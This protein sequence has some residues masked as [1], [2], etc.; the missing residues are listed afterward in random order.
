[1]PRLFANCELE[2]V[3]CPSAPKQSDEKGLTGDGGQ[4][5]S[6][7]SCC[8]FRPGSSP[9]PGVVIVKE[10]GWGDEIERFWLSWTAC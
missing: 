2:A 8:G 6:T 10:G 5:T 4:P 7:L 9:R 1:M 3:N